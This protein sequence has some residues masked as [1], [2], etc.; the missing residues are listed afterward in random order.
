MNH[1]KFSI[2]IFWLLAIFALILGGVIY[3]L[4]KGNSYISVFVRQFIPVLGE[5]IVIINS[6]CRVLYYLPDFLW[7]LSLSCGLHII[8]MPEMKGSLLCTFAVVG[9]GLVFEILQFLEFVNGTGDIIDVIMYL[10]AGMSVNLI[11]LKRRTI[12]G[13]YQS[14]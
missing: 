12:N 13:K 11:N 4:F 8:F 2:N 5:E 3:V 14:G 7:A 10:L 1:K 6:S 9:L